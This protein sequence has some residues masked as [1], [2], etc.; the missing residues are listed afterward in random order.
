MIVVTCFVACGDRLLWVQRAHDPKRGLWAIPGG[1][2]EQEETL[3]Q[4]AA[5]ELYEEAGVRISPDDLSLYMTGTIT[6]I[7]QIY[8]A[9]RAR[10]DSE[11]FLAGPESLACGFFSRNECPWE[12]LAYPEVNDCIEQAYD[13]LA[14][15]RFDVWQAEMLPGH[16]ELRPVRTRDQA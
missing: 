13:D 15:G 14:S 9:F 11:D 8:V 6:F 2:L 12:Q 16:Y 10:V 5:R 7:N 3:A 4:G 1:Y